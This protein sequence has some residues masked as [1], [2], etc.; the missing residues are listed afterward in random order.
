MLLAKFSAICTA[1]NSSLGIVD[2]FFDNLDLLEIN[3]LLLPDGCF[4]TAY[5][6]AHV[7]SK[8]ASP[9]T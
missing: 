3:P 4:M 6:T 7:P 8:L 5:A 9:N 2:C 1:T